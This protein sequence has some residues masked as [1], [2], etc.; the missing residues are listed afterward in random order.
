MSLVLCT[1]SVLCFCAF[2]VLT[3]SCNS[4]S[5]MSSIVIDFYLSTTVN[6]AN[7]FNQSEAIALAVYFYPR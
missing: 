7:V 5:E 1:A 4:V 3:L 6:V 2:K